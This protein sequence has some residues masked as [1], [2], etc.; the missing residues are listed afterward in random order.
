M[1]DI[2]KILIE[3]CITVGSIIGALAINHWYTIRQNKKNAEKLLQMLLRE[4]ERNRSVV[5]SYLESEQ[6]TIDDLE[7]IIQ[8]VSSISQEE[9]TALQVDEELNFNIRHESLHDSVYKVMLQTGA[10][11]FID[12]ALAIRFSDVYDVQKLFADTFNKM[13]ELAFETKGASNDK[14]RFI[15]VVQSLKDRLKMLLTVCDGL[16]N[17]YTGT[18]ADIHR[19]LK[20]N[21]TKKK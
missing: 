19:V 15:F 5:V 18:E 17:L 12:V 14:S 2:I 4:I 20:P 10:L 13:M 9:W 11:Q 6:K 1:S 8:R 3:V 16:F 21:K 7:T